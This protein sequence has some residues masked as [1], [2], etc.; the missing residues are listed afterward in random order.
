MPCE[1]HGLSKKK[2]SDGLNINILR[3][4]FHFPKP[5]ALI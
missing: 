3:R 2:N 5:A 1:R 4:A